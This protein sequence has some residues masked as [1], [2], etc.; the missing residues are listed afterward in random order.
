MNSVV[1][2]EIPADDLERVQKFY[3]EVFNWQATETME[4]AVMVNTTETHDNGIPKA[5][6][7]INGDFFK[8]DD[9]LK[10][11]LIVLTVDSIVEK[12][13]T[14]KNAGG[15]VVVDK[16]PVGDMGFCAYFKDSEG[17]VMGLWENP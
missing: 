2:F 11:P 16:M 6:G 17:N 5:A 8:R 15:S 1:H 9:N 4:G 3:N 14:I 12:F 13:E 10:H 7:A